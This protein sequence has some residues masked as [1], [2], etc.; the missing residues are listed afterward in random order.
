MNN[1]RRKRRRRRSRGGNTNKVSSLAA[2]C[3]PPKKWEAGESRNVG[4]ANVARKRAFPNNAKDWLMR[5]GNPATYRFL[6][7]LGK[8][9]GR[10][11]SEGGGGHSLDLCVHMIRPDTSPFPTAQLIH[12]SVLR[13]DT[14]TAVEKQRL[15]VYIDL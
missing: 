6:R 3:P 2:R 7:N 11:S 15:L 1:R 8:G 9:K 10:E 13:Y 14:C 12:L 4:L 5:P